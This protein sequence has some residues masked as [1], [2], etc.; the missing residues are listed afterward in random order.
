MPC[1]HLVERLSKT[2]RIFYI[3][4]FGALRD[5][6]QHDLGRCFS[7]VSGLFQGKNPHLQV[8]NMQTGVTVWQPWV[9]PTPRLSLIQAANVTLLRRSLRQLYEQYDIQ[10]PIIWARLP[11]PIVW[12]AIQGL[13]RS[14]LVYQS[15]DKFP[16]HPR[17]AQSLRKRYCMSERKFNENADV[18]FTSAR[19]LYDEKSQYNENTH[20]IP[21]GVGEGFADA[22]LIKIPTMEAISGPVVG[23]AGALG[24][25]TD[26]EWLVQLATGMPEVTFVFLGT[27]DRTE[28]L[29]GLESLENVILQG[30]VPHHELIS[31]FQYFDVGLMPYKINAFQDYTFPSKLAEYLMA[32]LPIV[33]T[34]LPELEHYQEVVEIADQPEAMMTD[35]RKL[36]E[37]D[38]RSD[39]DLLKQRKAVAATLT[40]E[41]QIVKIEDALEQALIR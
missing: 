18:V 10:S 6:D 38:A 34:H 26:I 24:T 8:G 27:I 29:L 20:F 5:L 36:L 19:G 14:L 37:S 23:F 13:D 2:H 15:I 33:A 16:E 17:I 1:H 28:P 39:P 41:A 25:A 40:W 21:N 35:I 22:Q 32:G 3:N 4:N 11:T 9:I 30:L 31:C 7:K 12:E